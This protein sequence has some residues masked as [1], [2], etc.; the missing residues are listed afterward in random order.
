MKKN[1]ECG[2]RNVGAR[3]LEPSIAGKAGCAFPVNAITE[4]ELKKMNS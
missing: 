3:A 4:F 2:L 1:A